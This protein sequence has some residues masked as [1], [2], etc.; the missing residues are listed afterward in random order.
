MTFLGRAIAATLLLGALAACRP[1]P[2][3][4]IESL[5]YPVVILFGNSS[6]RLCSGP[7]DLKKMHSN[8]IV[9]NDQPP[10]L[11]DS[12][13]KIY[14]LEHFRSVHSGLWLIANPSGVTEVAFDLSPKKGGLIEA[15][16]LFDQQLQKQSWRDDLPERQQ[17]LSRS[18][19]L[20]EMERTIS[21][22]A[23]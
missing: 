21:S 9:L 10:I 18:Q 16:R 20:L 4:S 15:R 22:E 2:A 8:Y 3:P 5:R 17:S 7:A 11:V 1:R 6:V 12:D 14:S 23:H 13:F 19:T